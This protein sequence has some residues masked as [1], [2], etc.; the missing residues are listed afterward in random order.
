[1]S[2]CRRIVDLNF[3]WSYQCGSEG[4]C[5]SCAAALTAER[6][7]LRLALE[8]QDA[9]M[10]A[11][12]NRAE[13][14]LNQGER[15]RAELKLLHDQQTEFAHDAILAGQEEAERLRAALE[16]LVVWADCVHRRVGVRMGDVNTGALQAAKDILAGNHG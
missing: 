8:R 1:M 12:I 11:C 14:F 5:L 15:L 10:T 3:G 2:G 16:N 9:N 6:D 7:R 4:L 13:F